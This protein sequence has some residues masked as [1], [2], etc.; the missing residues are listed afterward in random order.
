MS[1]VD[2]FPNDDMPETSRRAGQLLDLD[3]IEE[4]EDTIRSVPPCFED[5]ESPLSLP[6]VEIEIFEILEEE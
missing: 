6:F 1:N 5:A 3:T 2:I 4:D